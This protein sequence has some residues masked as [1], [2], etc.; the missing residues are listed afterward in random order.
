AFA[1]PNPKKKSEYEL[2][3]AILSG[4]VRYA[5]PG[6]RCA[7]E[8]IDLTPA[9][10]IEEVLT[11]DALAG[12]PRLLTLSGGAGATRPRLFLTSAG[13]K[14][15][16]FV[17]DAHEVLTTPELTKF[18]LRGSVAMDADGT[19][20]TCDLLEGMAAP[21]KAG[22]LVARQVVGR[23]NVVV[24]A[25]GTT[26][27]G[28][29]LEMQPEKGTA[30]LVGDARIV[31]KLGNEGVPAKEVTYDT[32]TR[33]WRMDSAPDEA[34]PGQVVRPKIFLGRDFTLPEVKNL[35]NGR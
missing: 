24:V 35:D 15:V 5:Q 6:L 23:G 22:H 32:Q 3:K 1:T 16:E 29:T 31:D 27:K 10:Q 26:A 2:N 8:R 12:R 7:A 34:N 25:S 18:F 20:A 21:D 11:K 9:V 14:N 4:R 30:R 13:G 28:R 19:D 17:A 33:A